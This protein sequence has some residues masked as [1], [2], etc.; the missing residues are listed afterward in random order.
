MISPHFD[1][2]RADGLIGKHILIGLEIRDRNENHVEDV[3]FH[4]NIIRVN[5]TEGVVVLLEP[6]RVEY[7][8]PAIFAAYEEA[9]PG[10][11]TLASTQEVI[12]D[13]DLLTTW[14]VY[15]PPDEA[16]DSAE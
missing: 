2:E 7:C 13:P 5:A 8:M 12:H 3:Q 6:S 11:Y 15:E 16:W 1:A 4:G 14:V 9:P 10:S